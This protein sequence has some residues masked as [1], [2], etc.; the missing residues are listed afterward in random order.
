MISLSGRVLVRSVVFIVSAT[1]LMMVL[2]AS[3]A[4][5]SSGTFDPKLLAG[6]V[7]IVLAIWLSRGSGIA[8]AALAILFFVGLAACVVLFVVYV[9][10][11]TPDDSRMPIEE[12]AIFTI[13]TV[14]SGFCFWALVLSK[15]FR[16]E[17]ALKKAAYS[18]RKSEE[19]KLYYESLGEDYKE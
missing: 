6:I 7:Y 19:K 3:L 18:K 9:F 10:F 14:V 1:G 2:F 5:I 11:A 4:S 17:L 12:L 16:S 13:T 8:R 15:A